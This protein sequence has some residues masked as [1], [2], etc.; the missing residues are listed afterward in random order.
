[1]LRRW[2]H[3]WNFLVSIFFRNPSTVE[4]SLKHAISRGSTVP[5][6]RCLLNACQE[7]KPVC[8]CVTAALQCCWDF[9]HFMHE[10]SMTNQGL[11]NR[12]SNTTLKLLCAHWVLCR[13]LTL[14]NCYE[15]HGDTKTYEWVISGHITANGKARLTCACIFGN[16][17]CVL[18]LNEWNCNH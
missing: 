16:S 18:E 4:I 9:L 17:S 15:D 6:L 14:G 2:A 11:L 8:M 10:I 7:C 12:E 1:M 13:L 5:H 3:G